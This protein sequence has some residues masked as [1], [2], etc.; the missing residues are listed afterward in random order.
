[1]DAGLHAY[2]FEGKASRTLGALLRHGALAKLCFRPLSH[3]TKSPEK[4]ASYCPL[5]TPRFVACSRIPSE[6]RNWSASVYSK[7]TD[8]LAVVKRL[9][10]L[11]N[12]KLKKLKS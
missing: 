8:R 5:P 12:R 3:L 9:K 1:M 6:S 11:N 10:K 2:G 7:A 4:M